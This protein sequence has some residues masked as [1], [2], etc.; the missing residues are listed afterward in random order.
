MPRIAEKFVVNQ[1]TNSGVIPADRTCGI[2]PQLH[3]PEMIPERIKNQKTID[4]K[5]PNP[6]NQFKHFCGLKDTDGSG[7]RS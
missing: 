4:E 5:L 6:K 7:H 2:P 3:F 1:F